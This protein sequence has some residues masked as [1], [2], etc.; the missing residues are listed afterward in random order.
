MSLTIYINP[1]HIKIIATAALT[2]V[3]SRLNLLTLSFISYFIFLL[4]ALQNSVLASCMDI[5]QTLLWSHLFSVSLWFIVASV[6]LL[7]FWQAQRIWNT[8]ITSVNGARLAQHIFLKQPKRTEYEQYEQNVLLNMWNTKSPPDLNIT[9]DKINCLQK[10][11]MFVGCGKGVTTAVSAQKTFRWFH[12]WNYIQTTVCLT[13][14][15][16]ILE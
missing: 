10:W 5:I 16:V 13:Y 11:I 15:W 4:S 1:R 9:V 2:S 7:F 14:Y 8:A 12:G 3:R 6:R